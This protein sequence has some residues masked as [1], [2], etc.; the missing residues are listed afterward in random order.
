MSEDKTFSPKDIEKALGISKVQLHYWAKLLELVPQ[1]KA[2][3][4]GMSNVYTL[5]NFVALRLVKTLFIDVG[6]KMEVA[7]KA[8]KELFAIVEFNTILRLVE[9][10]E[11][12]VKLVVGSD[13]DYVVTASPFTVAS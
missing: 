4:R 13:F 5:E 10:G 11:A 2:A 6:L 1:T 3:S 7:V 12:G 9:E 8:V